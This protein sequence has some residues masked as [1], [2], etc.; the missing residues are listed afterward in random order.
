M[1]NKKQLNQTSFLLIITIVLFFVMYGIG[2]VLFN[3]QGFSK[4]QNFLNSAINDVSGWI[5]FLDTKVRK[6]TDTQI[7]N[8][9][10]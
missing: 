3:A 1:K 2:C 5:K 9:S 8:S 7:Q 4:T 10:L 6:Q